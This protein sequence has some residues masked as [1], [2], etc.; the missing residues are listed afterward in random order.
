MSNEIFKA[1]AGSNG[2]AALVTVIDVKG[3]VPR[4]SGSKMLVHATGA[5]VGTVGGGRGEARAIETAVHCI[6]SKRSDALTVEMQGTEAEG[7]DMICGGACRMLVEYVAETR[8]YMTMLERVERGER[9]LLVKGLEGID[10]GTP[11]AVTVAVHDEAGQPVVGTVTLFDGE[12]AA[13]CLRTGVPA[14]AAET[15]LFYDPIFPEEKLLILGGGHVGRAVAVIARELDF[16]VTVADDR[17]ALLAPARF[18]PGVR[19]MCGNYADVAREFPLDS[20]SYVVIVTRAK[21]TDLECIRAVLGRTFRYAGF[22]GSARKARILLDQLK[23]DGFAQD[24]IDRVHS[25]IGVD[26]G[27]ETP[28]EIAVSILAEMIAVRR[29]AG[30]LRHPSLSRGTGPQEREVS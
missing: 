9:V 4:H 1:I 15:G 13:R 6:R 10:S 23:A 26:I 17:E 11:G 18:A 12:I 3:S 21:A 2:D 30:S 16:T 20:A 7:D 25:P 5:I 24:K 28:A 14:F 8:P 19:T 29:N 22:I 27:S